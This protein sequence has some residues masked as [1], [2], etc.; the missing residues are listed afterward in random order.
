[1]DTA[2]ILF[3]KKWHSAT[4]RDTAQYIAIYITIWCT[5]LFPPRILK[6]ARG[7]FPPKILGGN[8]PSVQYEK[9]I[10]LGLFPPKVGLFPPKHK[11]I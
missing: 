5:D 8:S 9:I 6:F 4:T 7:L 1:M 3:Q 10:L 2:Q 11:L